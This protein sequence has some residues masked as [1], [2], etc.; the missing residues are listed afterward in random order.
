MADNKKKVKKKELDESATEEKKRFESLSA[1]RS[2]R[3]KM[4]DDDSDERVVISGPL[5]WVEK[6]ILLSE[7]FGVKK[8]LQAILFIILFIGIDFAYN[9]LQNEDTVKSVIES[10][11]K[12]EREQHEESSNVRGYVSPKINET[13]IKL[14]YELHADRA[15]VM[16][17]HNGKENASAL[18]FVYLDMTYEEVRDGENVKYV[19]PHFE[20]INI[21][22]Y[23]MPWY[24]SDNVYFIGGIDEIKKIDKRFAVRF[25]DEGG[26]YCG[27]ILVRSNGI[28][29]GFLGVSYKTPHPEVTDE[30]IH[31][32]LTKYVQD[33]SSLL[34][35]NKAKNI[36]EE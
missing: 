32:K 17:M 9:A 16:E 22:N 18:P 25:E 15:F 36:K 12:Q 24:L 23:T 19:Q 5:G 30:T 29:I 31:N 6:V 3:R 11:N 13:L 33:I 7:R 14:V 34:D 21:N 10:V 4:V 20:N 28:N 1:K 27:L 2:K 8:L 35:L 26:A